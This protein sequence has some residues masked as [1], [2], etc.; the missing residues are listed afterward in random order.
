[1][2][3]L[4]QDKPAQFLQHCLDGKAMKPLTQVLLDRRATPHFKE[5]PVPEEY[6]EA[7][8]LFGAQ[9]PSGYNLQPWRFIVVRKKENRERLQKA[10]YNQEKI[11]E[12]PVI[13]IAFGGRNDWKNYLDEIFGEGLSR[14]YGK[15]EMV[16]QIK[17]QAA[18]FL[19]K[20]IPQ[21]V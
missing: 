1:M 6:L 11:V 15:P 21:N 16:S 2:K 9:A 20:A 19:E 10:A 5:N 4:F 3:T 7:I 12:A 18:V 17:K 8:L 13:I 14:G